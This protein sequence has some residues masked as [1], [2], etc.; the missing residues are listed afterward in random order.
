MGPEGKVLN[1][2]PRAH[3]GDTWGQ[4]GL[5]AALEAVPLGD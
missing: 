3:M 4:A 1:S 5:R 2:E